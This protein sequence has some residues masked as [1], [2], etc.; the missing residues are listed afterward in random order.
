[1]S[2]V[3]NREGPIVHPGGGWH[4]GWLAGMF[5]GSSFRKFTVAR[6]FRRSVMVVFRHSPR[7][8]FQFSP[9]F[10]TSLAVPPSCLGVRQGGK[11]T[12]FS[13][14]LHSV[15]AV[16]LSNSEAL[17]QSFDPLPRT[18]ADGHWVW[19]QVVNPHPTL[20]LVDYLRDELAMTGTKR[21]CKEGGCGCCTV[22]EER[23][24]D[25][26]VRQIPINS[27]LRP[28]CSLDGLSIR[29]ADTTQPKDVVQRMVE[30]RIVV[31]KPDKPCASGTQCGYCT[32]GMVMTA[33][34]LLSSPESREQVR[35]RGGLHW[36]WFGEWRRREVLQRLL[37]KPHLETSWWDDSVN[38]VMVHWLRVGHQ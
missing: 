12:G 14:R 17:T 38:E 11:A 19:M 30:E 32:P 3:A 15:F 33:Y 18:N 29:T 2:A 4:T 25:D 7:E 28:V 6:G 26:D 9:A 13:W 35:P 10:K 36:G 34:S 16:V 23:L 24:V 8:M 5:S 22:M 20:L 27:C 21:M 31:P 37:C 1:M